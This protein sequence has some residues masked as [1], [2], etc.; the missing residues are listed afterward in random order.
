MLFPVL[1]CSYKTSEHQNTLNN[2]NIKSVT[3]EIVTKLISLERN[4]AHNYHFKQ[5]SSISLIFLKP[6]CSSHPSWLQGNCLPCQ[7]PHPI[8]SHFQCTWGLWRLL[9]KWK[10]PSRSESDFYKGKFDHEKL[11]MFFHEKLRVLAQNKIESYWK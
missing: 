6:T 9:P 8:F 7:I 2:S 5:V 1:Y 10:E 4:S 3:T 11:F